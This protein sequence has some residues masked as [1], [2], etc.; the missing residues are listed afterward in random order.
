LGTEGGGEGHWLI[1][2]KTLIKKNKSFGESA[3][4]DKKDCPVKRAGLKSGSKSLR[5]TEIWVKHGGK[6]SRA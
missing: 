3:A 4:Q 1:I 2:A 6:S 5:S